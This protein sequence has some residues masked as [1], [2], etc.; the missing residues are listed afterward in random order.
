MYLQGKRKTIYKM[1]DYL[2]GTRKRRKDRGT[3]SRNNNKCAND[4]DLTKYLPKQL[5]GKPST[6]P[7]DMSV[8]FMS[9]PIQ[10]SSGL[11]KFYSA[12]LNICGIVIHSIRT[13]TGNLFIL[14][15]NVDFLGL[16]SRWFDAQA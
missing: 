8:P 16:V 12:F 9:L 10:S 5:V 15:I 1:R 11:G 2:Y 4:S 7:F 13:D 14:F 3:W 6:T